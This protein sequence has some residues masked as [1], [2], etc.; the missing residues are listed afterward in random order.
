MSPEELTSQLSEYLDEMS[1]IIMENEGTIDK[2]IGDAIMAFWGAPLDIE[3]PVL[4]AVECAKKMQERL[5]ELEIKWQKEG[6]VVLKQEL[7]SIM[8]RP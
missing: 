8:V 7:V 1:E 4:K 5:D 3:N 6:K 2:Y